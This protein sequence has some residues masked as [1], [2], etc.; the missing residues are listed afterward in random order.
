MS[1]IW[2]PAYLVLTACLLFSHEQAKA[3]VTVTPWS[4]LFRGVEHATG[5]KVPGGGDNIRQF[6]SI[7]R[8]D[9]RDPDIRLLSTPR[10]P[11]YV[12]GS[13]E[14]GAAGVSDFLEA[15]HVQVAINAN[16]YNP[17][18]VDDLGHAMNVRGL[19]I[20]E[21]KLVGPPDPS[22]YRTSI[23]I[24]TNN[25]VSF[26]PTN[27]PVA[28]TN[29][30]FTAVTGDY[31]LIMNGLSVAKNSSSPVP[32]ANPRTA[33]G[34]TEDGR[35]LLMMT[36]DGRQPG[37]SDGSE[38][39]DTAA[40]LIRFG[41]HNG[42]NLDGGGSTTMS[43]EY[44]PGHAMRLNRPSYLL[45]RGRERYVGS[46]LGVFAK[47]LSG[48]ISNVVT[49]AGLSAALVQWKTLAPATSQ[50]QYG[51]TTNYGSFTTLDTSL[52]TDH[53]VTIEGFKP[54]QTIYFNILSKAAGITY[55]NHWCFTLGS[56]E[57]VSLFGIDKKWKYQVASQDGQPWTKT[58]FNDTK[59]PEG[60]GLLYI[61][62]SP[63]VDPKTTLLPFPTPAT[64][65]PA[66]TY[67]FRSTFTNPFPV[68][69]ISL[70]FSNFLDDGAVFYLNGIEIQRIYMPT[71]PTPI[72]S[73]T[74]ATGFTCVGGDATCPA[75]FT[76]TGDPLTNL[77]S[78]VNVLAVEVH[79]YN[80][81]S[82]DIVFGS[83]L[84]GVPGDVPT[85]PPKLNIT[86]NSDTRKIRIAWTGGSGFALQQSVNV[87]PSASWSP[88]PSGGTSPVLL[89]LEAGTRYFRLRSP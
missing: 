16:F 69:P 3:T 32:G 57:P 5:S 60:A 65:F 2:N 34:A 4:P 73:T 72:L 23:Y 81:K 70:T 85:K 62:D 6:V 30:I 20:S 41:A 27:W 38:D 50:I 18:E 46:H 84:S 54:G 64:G 61:E 66:I 1:R 63:A 78:G 74:L 9:L 25:E 44:C 24:S 7:L 22:Q 51:V 33:I 35:Y 59:W 43:M 12:Q 89:S 11:N 36:I 21:G 39:E 80:A 83:A 88:I 37:W 75:I 79:N 55:S 8:I 76:L 47:P 14:T 71:E 31:P 40:W 82:P 45:A 52:T 26:H 67:Y 13:Q 42:L 53:E 68:Q 15:N 56:G 49:E 58:N 77:V 86:F 19:H 28:N 29:G 87:G 17:N 48:F 10:L